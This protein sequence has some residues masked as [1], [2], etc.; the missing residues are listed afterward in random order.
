MGA[1]LDDV[2][3]THSL[4]HRAE[5]WEKLKEKSLKDKRELGLGLGLNQAGQVN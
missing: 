5:N 2:T 3:V 4:L 1:L